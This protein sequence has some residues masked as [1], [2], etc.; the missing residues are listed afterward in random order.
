MQSDAK[1]A[2]FRTKLVAKLAA[3]VGREDVLH[4]RRDLLAYA[5]DAEESGH[6]PDAVVF[7]ATS[8]EVARVVA[9]CAE[10]R[11]PLVARGAGTN[12]SGGTI[13]VA[14]GVVLELSRLTRVAE[15]SLENRRVVA[16]PGVVNLDIQN[17]LAKSGY[18]FAPDP[19]SQKVS[20]LGGNVGENSG[21][22]HCFKYGVMSNHVLGLEVAL[23]DGALAH[24][25]GALEDSP[26]YDLTGLFVGS[27]GTLGVATS[28]T[29]KVLRSTE[30]V[31]TLL[32]VFG[33]IGDAGRAVAA[34]VAAG[35][36]PATLEFV[37]KGLLG[38]IQASGD[39]GFPTDAACI[40]LIEVDG[41]T[42]E[43]DRQAEEIAAIC[44]REG[45]SETRLAKTAAERNALWAGRRSAF[46]SIARISPAYVTM[47]GTVPRTRLADMLVRMVEIGERHGLNV[48]GV[49]HAGDGN[50][51]PV[52]M[53]D[54]KN[55]IEVAQMRLAA[56]NILRACVLVGGTLTG[57]HGIGIAKRAMMSTLFRPPE[58]RLFGRV[59]RAFDPNGV[60]NPGKLLPEEMPEDVTIAKPAAPNS[61][62]LAMKLLTVHDGWLSPTLDRY[63]VGGVRPL[64]AFQA[65]TVEAA[66]L[67]VVAA[68]EHGVPVVPW[69]CGGQQ[70]VGRTRPTE[71][72]VLDLSRLDRIVEVDPGNQTVDVEAG[73]TLGELQA[74]AA[75]HGL[76]FP[77]DPDAAPEM[78]I[79]GLVATAA[80]GPRRLGYG[81]PR[82]LVLGLRVV[83]PWGEVA[84]VGGRTMKDVAG[85][86]TRKLFVGSW[87]TLGAIVEAT[88]RVYPLP[89]A[90]TTLAA[91][92]RDVSAAGAALSSLLASPLQPTALELV[93]GAALAFDGG[94]D[95]AWKSL[96]LRLPTLATGDF[97]V[98][99]RLEGRREA[100]ERLERDVAALLR[101]KGADV[102]ATYRGGAEAAIWAARQG[103]PTRAVAAGA[104]SARFS[105]PIS[106]AADF[107]G[108]APAGAGLAASAGSGVGRAFLP[109]GRDRVAL[110][111][112]LRQAAGLAGGFVVLDR[113]EPALLA[114]HGGLP[115]RDDYALM[116]RLRAS[117]DPNGTFNPGRVFEG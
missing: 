9:L 74:E 111:A 100:V 6:E 94:V 2:A 3:I 95:G 52:I 98:L 33:E 85:Y 99:A 23:A 28:A 25:G 76:F 44:R 43:L 50:L 105:V 45:A 78:T 38:A 27:E 117:I 57:E 53:F 91:R 42:D 49:A 110:L 79:G 19:A 36:I 114:E 60:M 77:V 56:A 65:R 108:W 29:L 47:D 26:G 31:R 13:P 90:S 20:T 54:P 30:S 71:C 69:G 4:A 46:G 70:A 7:P 51:H 62:A 102:L 32:A 61:S 18:V 58:L 81:L 75:K 37:D 1:L 59:K 35:L 86:D 106:K 115:P 97:V 40:L 48:C 16:E 63:R 64:V 107:C 101:A 72:L 82:D 80:A 68:V 10:G 116:A 96:L 83:T 112:G 11:V 12:L 92:F 93:N 84:R 5:Y 73:V 14:G 21:G 89:E 24:F 109:T 87:G 22:P 67:A 103:L 55:P 15:I 17:L 66:R 8:E 34:I 113:A 104:A 39:Y 88:L 41:L